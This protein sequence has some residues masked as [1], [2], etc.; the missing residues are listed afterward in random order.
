MFS[1]FCSHGF[2]CNSF[3]R[4]TWHNFKDRQQVFQSLMINNNCVSRVMHCLVQRWKF[5]RVFFV[6]FIHDRDWLKFFYRKKTYDTHID[7]I[8]KKWAMNIAIDL[9]DISTKHKCVFLESKIPRLDLFC[10]SRKVW[11]EMGIKSDEHKRFLRWWNVW[12]YGCSWVLLSSRTFR[13]RSGRVPHWWPWIFL[14]RGKAHLDNESKFGFKMPSNFL[15]TTRPDSH[16]GVGRSIWTKLGTSAWRTSHRGRYMINCVF[17]LQ[18]ILGIT[19]YN[20][21]LLGFKTG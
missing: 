20:S 18:I 15:L 14:V 2:I 12:G 6:D 7:I 19:R 1:Y 3:Q 16:T 17:M 4:I 11:C 9:F 10:S 21:V 13:R 8:I 5:G